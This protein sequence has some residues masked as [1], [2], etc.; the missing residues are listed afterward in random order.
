MKIYNL[1]IKNFRGIKAA[2]INLGKTITC[3]IGPGDSTKSTILDAIEYVLSPNWFIL[4]DDTD[5]TFCDPSE[6]IKIQ[7]TIGPVPD[8]LISDNK[9]GLFLRG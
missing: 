7:V 1:D 9:Y 5:F 3:L 8:E 4:F 6:P 2:K